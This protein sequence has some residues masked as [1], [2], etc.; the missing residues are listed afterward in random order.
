MST[1][2]PRVSA[3]IATKLREIAGLADDAKLSLKTLGETTFVSLTT[4]IGDIDKQ[5]GGL[6]DAGAA[7]ADRMS[8]AFGAAATKMSEQ[9][10]ALE[11]QIRE[12]KVAPSGGGGGGG[13]AGM[14]NRTGGTGGP[15]AA[16]SSGSGGFGL[17]AEAAGWGSLAAIWE[18]AK[19]SLDLNK[20]QENLKISGVSDAEIA[21]AT[22]YAK[23]VG[24]KYGIVP[25]QILQGLNEMRNPLNKGITADQGMEDAMRHGET[26]ARAAIVL[27]NQGK[28]SNGDISRELY[29]LVKSAEFRNSI[30]D[31]QFDKAVSS[32]VAAD[33]ATGGIVRPREW[34]QTSQM[35]KSALPGMSNDYLYTIIP[36]LMQEFGGSRA[37]TA[38]MSLYQQL[39]GGHM[40][41]RGSQSSF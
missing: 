28:D 35:L 38:G 25:A 39:I 10:K 3:G 30:G 4:K 27:R 6:G 24:S 9:I 17:A 20:V 14:F 26:L 36:E 13:R 22:Q 11:T 19:A 32:M 12:M 23:E 29:D 7:A 8:N 21:K 15:A 37:G 5:L 31:A 41:T 34:L 16:E 2:R 33:V 1:S 18:C 40:T